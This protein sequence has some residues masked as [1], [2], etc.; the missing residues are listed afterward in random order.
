MILYAKKKTWHD[1]QRC[2][3]NK[4]QMNQ[5]IALKVGTGKELKPLQAYK[6]YR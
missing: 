3:N 4:Q 5:T 6:H 1:K 2:T